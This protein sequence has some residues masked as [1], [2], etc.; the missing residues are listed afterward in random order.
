MPNGRHQLALGVHAQSARAVSEL[1]S[2]DAVLE[3]LNQVNEDVDELIVLVVVK[4]PVFTNISDV[5]ALTKLSKR[6][7]V[8]VAQLEQA[9]AGDDAILATLKKAQA[10]K[11][12]MLRILVRSMKARSERDFENGVNLPKIQLNA[13]TG[14]LTEE[15]LPEVRAHE[16]R[17][18]ARSA[19]VN[20]LLRVREEQVALLGGCLTVILS[21][22][23]G[24]L[25]SRVLTR[26]IER[27]QDNTFRLASRLELNSP[28]SGSDELAVLDQSFQRLARTLKEKER[29]ET[30]FIDGAADGIVALDNSH[31]ITF[32]NNSFIDLTGYS[33]NELKGKTIF[34]FLADSAHSKLSQNLDHAQKQDIKGT[35]DAELIG[36]KAIFQ[37]P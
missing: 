29:R 36:K 21:V 3:C 15:L 17:L 30:L 12:E 2:V 37:T 27:L 16:Q 5:S 23:A 32:S 11:Q 18:A 10:I 22:I 34:S 7:D 31:R 33:F 35:L 28:D 9:S 25:L 13:L 6:L 1:K 4:R 8:H 14:R 19:S 24:A 26:R 20:N